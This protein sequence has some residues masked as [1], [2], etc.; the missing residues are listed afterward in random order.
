MKRQNFRLSSKR[1][2]LILYENYLAN[3][4]SNI[5]IIFYI[6]LY[7]KKCLPAEAPAHVGTKGLSLST[8][9]RII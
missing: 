2:P 6:F 9:L 3:L 5:N 7:T 4:M 8:P 1:K